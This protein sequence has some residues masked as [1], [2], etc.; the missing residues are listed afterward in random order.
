MTNDLEEKS[1]LIEM[2]TSDPV[3]TQKVIEQ[4]GLLPIEQQLDIYDYYK[5]LLSNRSMCNS[6]LGSGGYWKIFE[7]KSDKEKL[8]VAASIILGH[9]NKESL[10]SKKQQHN[11]QAASE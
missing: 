4:I 10:P 3:I 7:S 11:E 8:Q 1:R 9:L 2:V 5:K 6:I